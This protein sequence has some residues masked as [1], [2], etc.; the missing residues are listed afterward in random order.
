MKKISVLGSTGSI[1]TQT[2]QV[3]DASDNLTVTALST[4]TNIDL[5]EKQIKKYNPAVAAV[6]NRD[7]AEELKKRLS[8]SKTK[9]LSGLDGLI[10]AASFEDADISVISVAGNIGLKPTY[11]AIKNHKTIA[12]ATKEVL[13]SAGSII[14]EEAHRQGVK[15]L[16]VDSEHSAIFQSLQGNDMN[17]IRK[18]LLTASGGPFRQTPAEELR[19]VTVEDALKH[20]N[21]SMGKKITVDSASMM[22][23]G[24]EVIEAKWL[25]NV[26][27]DQIEVVV[28]PQSIVHSAVEYA[29]GAVI[30]QMGTPDM[31]LPIAYAL[32]YPERVDLGFER[33]DIFKTGHLD[34]YKPDTEKFKCL[35]LAYRAVKTGGTMPAVMNVANEKAV[36]LFLDKKI[37]FTDIPFLIEKAMDAYTVKYDYSI[38]D[39]EQADL[40]ARRETENFY[41]LYIKK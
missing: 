9:I 18:I 25:F 30:A 19:Y 28:H 17:P 10:K 16:P 21:W 31:R 27:V 4:N 40:W 7:R 29:D 15:I 32:N 35:S 36:A 2:L 8:G 13:V 12:L 38:D 20:P 33:L 22:N 23:K 39:I 37:G 26:D 34:F 14:M 11:E 1:G 5:L 3:I 6:Y 41:E 24:L